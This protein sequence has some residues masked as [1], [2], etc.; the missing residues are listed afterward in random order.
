MPDNQSKAPKVVLIGLNYAPEMT[1]IAPYTTGLA[2][3]L[4]SKGAQVSAITG[5]PHY[6]EWKLLPQHSK[7][8]R[9]SCSNGVIVNRTNHYIPKRPNT[10]GRLRLE[11]S[12][13]VRSVFARWGSPD[14]VLCVSPSLMSSAACLLRARLSIS[15][16]STIVWVQDFYSKGIAE[17]TSAP[18]IVGRA[19][20]AF[21]K[22]TLNLADHVVVIH[23]RFRSVAIDTLG[24]DA[25]KITIARN[26]THIDIPA[27]S[28]DPKAIRQQ[29]GWGDETIVLHAGN[30]GAKQGLEN[31]VAAARLADD[32]QAP[33]KFVLLG[34]GN[35]R[36]RLE[37]MGE[38]V[39]RIQFIDPLPNND[40]Y[41]ALSAAD[42]LL[43]NE[44]PTVSEMAVPSKLTTY[45]AAE[46]PIIAATNATSAS[47]DELRAAGAS[48][49]I[50]P[51]NPSA[52]LAAT[53]KLR[54]DAASCRKLAESGRRYQLDNLT[55]AASLRALDTVV[56]G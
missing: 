9:K 38:H 28:R 3:H 27:S 50:E 36:P 1:G 8:R 41:A 34:D 51:G 19:A 35:Q 45:F 17:T 12:Y 55:P 32:H 42:I 7:I 23:D 49:L 4:A 44:K 15:R 18:R 31:V 30:I 39:R 29:F 6:P 48:V 21:E 20:R 46:R 24:V 47:A 22:W 5:L 56:F 10:F 33:V 25:D 2:E 54:N 13:A 37:Q 16:P 53:L 40:F 26:W 11:A 52:L 43:L 14:A